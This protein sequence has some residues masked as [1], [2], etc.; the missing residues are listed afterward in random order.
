MPRIQGAYSPFCRL[1]HIWSVPVFY[2]L[3]RPLVF[4]RRVEA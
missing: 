1:I 2:L 3:R 4:R